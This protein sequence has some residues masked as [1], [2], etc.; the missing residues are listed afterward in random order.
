MH[1][2]SHTALSHVI[3]LALSGPGESYHEVHMY[4]YI[5]S[6]NLPEIFTKHRLQLPECLEETNF[7]LVE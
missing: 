7:P 4:R 6:T 2:V 1:D 3:D 5:T